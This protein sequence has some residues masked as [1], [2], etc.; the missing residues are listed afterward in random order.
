MSASAEA[1]PDPGGKPA[2]PLWRVGE[3]NPPGDDV[4]VQYVLLR[5][6]LIDRWPLGTVIAAVCSRHYHPD[7]LF[8]CF[9][10]NLDSMHKVKGETQLRNLSNKLKKEGI[11]HKLW[12]EQPDD[13]PACLLT[14]PYPKSQVAPFFKKLKLCK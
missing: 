12:V 10:C 1:A 5:R 4:V 8:Y 9:D 6:D 2:S 7:V 14:R 13:F 11:D 3:G